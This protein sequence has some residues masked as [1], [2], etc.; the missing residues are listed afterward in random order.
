VRSG[1]D[2]NLSEGNAWVGLPDASDLGEHD[3]RLAIRIGWRSNEAHLSAVF[4]VERRP[5]ASTGFR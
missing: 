3:L 4:T 5:A 2:R 1:Q